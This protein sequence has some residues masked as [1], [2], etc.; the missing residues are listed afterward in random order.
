ML[1]LLNEISATTIGIIALAI[2][3]LIVIV[4]IILNYKKG[5]KRC[6]IDISL[7]VVS[8][9]LSVLLTGPVL[10]LFDKM[11][12]F[13]MA[14]FSIFMFQFGNIDIFNIQVT[15]S[16][17]Q[18]VVESFKNTEI[19]I[20]NTL[21]SFLINIFKTTDIQSGV[22][23]NLGS[24]ASTAL[25]YILSFVIVSIIIFVVL[26]TLLKIL[27]N[28]IIKRK[29]TK[30]KENNLKF[31]AGILGALQGFA[32]YVLIVV[33]ISSTHILGLS[34][35]YLES[36]YERTAILNSG[37]Q[38]LVN[39]ENE[40]FQNKIDSSV[41]NYSMQ[42][43]NNLI[44]IYKADEESFE[45]SIEVLT[46][47]LILNYKDSPESITNTFVFR[48][49]IAQNKIFIY[50]DDLIYNVYNYNQNNKT[51]QIKEIINDKEI[52]TTLNLL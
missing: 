2:L 21:K 43:N 41:T 9:V 25:S 22:T 13:S 40:F 52:S 46:K 37:Y 42:E 51:I 36:G 33:A 16:N 31:V 28:F 5:I 20:S 1:N 26:F 23:T 29:H 34:T 3:T 39:T 4:F 18:A 35:D 10:S 50:K 19:G 15:S 48:Y 8:V 17:Y 30:N 47:N 11:F 12:S 27:K 6:V 44:G 7:F 24:I 38:L 45:L 14:F 49:I 32:V